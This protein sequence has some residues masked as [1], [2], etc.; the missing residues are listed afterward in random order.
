MSSR[1]SSSSLSLRNKFHALHQHPLALAEP[2]PAP[3]TNIRFN[4]NLRPVHKSLIMTQSGADAEEP[5]SLRIAENPLL[6]PVRPSSSPGLF[7]TKREREEERLYR[8][9]PPPLYPGDN[10]DRRRLSSGGLL[11]RGNRKK[12]LRQANSLM[13]EGT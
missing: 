5:V 7:L 3:V 8:L 4:V 13:M 1:R 9:S 2:S 11:P 10:R 12:R 6:S